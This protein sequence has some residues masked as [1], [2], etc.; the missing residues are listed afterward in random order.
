MRGGHDGPLV[1]GGDCTLP[2]H[3]WTAEWADCPNKLGTSYDLTG[4]RVFT[5]AGFVDTFRQAHPDVCAVEGRTWTPLSD[6]RLITPQRIDMTFTRGSGL[7]V[8]DARTVDTRM[9]KHGPGTFYSDH[10]R[11]RHRPRRPLAS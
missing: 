4:T 6:E 7:S 2:A 10:S 8:V 11:R 3:D 5:D 1:I 9:P